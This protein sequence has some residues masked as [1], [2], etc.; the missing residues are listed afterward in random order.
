MR[1]ESNQAFLTHVPL[2]F[3]PI[4]NIEV[5]RGECPCSCVHCPVGIVPRRIR[6]AHFGIDQMSW[7]LFE[8]ITSE[9]ALHSAS[10][11]RFHA[12]GDPL[13]WPA[14]KRALSLT[15]SL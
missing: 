7:L 8:K 13:L 3:P 2:P 11:L 12:T 15:Q 5:L 9:V 10:C 14:L 4:V 6:A 1:V